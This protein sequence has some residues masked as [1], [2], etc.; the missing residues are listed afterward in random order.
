MRESDL[1]E[2]TLRKIRKCANFV[3]V[4]FYCELAGYDIKTLNSAVSKGSYMLK[5][6]SKTV[7]VPYT[8][9]KKAM[10]KKVDIT[11]YILLCIN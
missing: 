8:S 2:G 6:G 5:V 3:K 9:V 4:T 11:L 10:E 7:T 1:E